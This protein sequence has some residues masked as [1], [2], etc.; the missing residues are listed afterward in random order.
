MATGKK[1]ADILAEL[2]KIDPAILENDLEE[3]GKALALSKQLT[4]T[5][6]V[7]MHRAVEY[8]FKVFQLPGCFSGRWA[9]C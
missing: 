5:L 3:K 1:P 4:A 9:S 6:E 2:A 8:I 7:P